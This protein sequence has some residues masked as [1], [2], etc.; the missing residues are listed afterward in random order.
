[1]K[2]PVVFKL[3]LQ[4]GGDAADEDIQE[5]SIEMVE[6]GGGSYAAISTHRWAIDNGESLREL[7]DKIDALIK[8]YDEHGPFSE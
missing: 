2:K 7:A 8:D 6:A 4:Q 3:T 5:L 1:M